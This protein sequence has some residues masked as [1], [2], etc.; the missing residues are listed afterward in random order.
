MNLYIEVEFCFVNDTPM[1]NGNTLNVEFDLRGCAN[2]M[3]QT[4][5]TELVDCKLLNTNFNYSLLQIRLSM[6]VPQTLAPR[7]ESI[8]YR[9]YH[10]GT[11]MVMTSLLLSCLVHQ[12]AQRKFLIEHSEQ[13]K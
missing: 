10:R 4:T 13:V 3:C 8:Q 9:V 2:V 5:T 7:W 1:V 12:M 6:Q 11:I